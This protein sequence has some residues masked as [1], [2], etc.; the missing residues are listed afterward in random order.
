[1]GDLTA[2]TRLALA[3]ALA[4]A[5]MATSVSAAAQATP[6]RSGHEGAANAAKKKKRKKKCRSKHKSPLANALSC[7]RLARTLPNEPPTPAGSEVYDFCRNNTYRYRKVN[8]AFDGRS[9]TTTYRGRWKAISSTSGSAGVSGAIQYSVTNFRSVYSDGAPAE[10]PP[11]SLLSE[12]I[13]FGPFGVDFAGA[14]Y[15]LGKA[16][17]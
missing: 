9:F 4:A 15:L 10:P 12:A 17:C 11:P 5:L 14:R 8:F 13:V 2:R 1:V 6:S 16:P 7:R 3:A